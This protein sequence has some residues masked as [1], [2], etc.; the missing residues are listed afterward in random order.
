VNNIFDDIQ[1]QSKR[2]KVAQNVTVYT[3]IMDSFQKMGELESLGQYVVQARSLLFR[4]EEA[5]TNVKGIN[6]EE[7]YF[8][9]EVTEYPTL[10]KV[11][12]TYLF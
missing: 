9:W 3:S 5:I 4:L 1:K 11:S 6:E 7:V 10:A 2:G 8:E 12:L